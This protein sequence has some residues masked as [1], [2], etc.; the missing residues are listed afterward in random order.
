[1]EQSEKL[2]HVVEYYS[3]LFSLHLRHDFPRI[4]N[5]ISCYIMTIKYTK[6]LEFHHIIKNS[7]FIY[8]NVRKQLSLHNRPCN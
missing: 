8:K 4:N 1:M 6:E 5:T 7:L 2:H 3:R